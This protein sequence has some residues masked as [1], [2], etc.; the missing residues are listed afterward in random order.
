MREHK[1]AERSGEGHP[2]GDGSLATV[3][4]EGERNKMAMLVRKAGLLLMT[5]LHFLHK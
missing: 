2:T 1:H 4:W 5:A 3:V